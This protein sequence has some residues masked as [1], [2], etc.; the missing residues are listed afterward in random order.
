M[1]LKFIANLLAIAHRSFGLIF[2]IVTN[3]TN[4]ERLRS[5]ITIS[6]NN[7]YYY[8]VVFIFSIILL[9]LVILTNPA[10]ATNTSIYKSHE[11]SKSILFLVLRSTHT[12]NSLIHNHTRCTLVVSV[13]AS[14]NLTSATEA[15][16]VSPTH[17]SK[18]V[19]IL[20][21][22]GFSATLPKSNTEN[23][24]F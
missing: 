20:L 15:T 8:Q 12:A 7:Y 19:P 1:S 17:A 24:F 9:S 14:H 11:S 13:R 10:H 23:S 16:I 6:C 21:R 22:G 3:V 5:K 18:E 2:V 4:Y